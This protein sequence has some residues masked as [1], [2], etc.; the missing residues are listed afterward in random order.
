MVIF[1]DDDVSPMHYKELESKAGVESY[2]I[3]YPSKEYDIEGNFLEV[4]MTVRVYVPYLIFAR[5]KIA[6]GVITY[7]ITK[8]LTGKI[9]VSQKNRTINF[10]DNKNAI[11]STQNS[12]RLNVNLHDPHGKFNNDLF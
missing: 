5:K 1:S 11:V 12:T 6:S 3:N 2:T 8:F 10:D 7:R 9:E 4:E